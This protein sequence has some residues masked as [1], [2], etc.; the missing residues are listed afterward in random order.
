MSTSPSAAFRAYLRQHGPTDSAV[1]LAG[2]GYSA[3]QSPSAHFHAK[4][5]LG[6]M[7]GSGT[8]VDADGLVSLP[9]QDTQ[10]ADQSSDAEQF[11]AI[12]A[13]YRNALRARGFN[14][15][16]IRSILVALIRTQ[17]VSHIGTVN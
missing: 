7:I 13:D 1:L 12:L 14:N 16:D 4:L 10:V 15:P 8:L 9:G 17:H 11:A 5:H 2:C 3:E 6:F